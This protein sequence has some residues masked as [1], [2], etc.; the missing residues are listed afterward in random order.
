MTFNEE[1]YFSH[2]YLDN[3]LLINIVG[4]IPVN[5]MTQLFLL[6]IQLKTNLIEMS[7]NPYFC[8]GKHKL[9]KSVV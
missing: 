8:F 5:I 9:S 7:K 6:T 3:E 2:I 1:S 4:E